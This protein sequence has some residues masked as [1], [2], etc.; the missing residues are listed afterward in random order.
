VT[1]F[2][3]VLVLDACFDTSPD[4]LLVE[5]ALTVAVVIS[6]IPVAVSRVTL[7]VVFPSG[8]STHCAVIKFVLPSVTVARLCLPIA[9]DTNVLTSLLILLSRLV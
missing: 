9:T 6:A 1:V 2:V 4:S 5:V 7:V 3:A 8:I